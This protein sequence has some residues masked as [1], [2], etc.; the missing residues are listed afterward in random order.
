MTRF[1]TRLEGSRDYALASRLSLRPSVEAGLRHYSGGRVPPLMFLPKP[2]PAGV[3]TYALSTRRGDVL[4]RRGGDLG[5]PQPETVRGLCR[6]DRQRRI[7]TG[8]M[9]MPANSRPSGVWALGT[10][11]PAVPALAELALVDFLAARARPAGLRRARRRECLLHEPLRRLDVR[12]INDPQLGPCLCR[13]EL[14]GRPRSVLALDV[15]LDVVHL[16][17]VLDVRDLGQN[18]CAIDS[19]VSAVERRGSTSKQVANIIRRA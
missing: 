9:L 2:T 7:R 10:V 5:R 19:H 17:D 4:V 14:A 15:T 3:S 18:R 12:R 8:E 16:E 6:T 13:W 11:R 1:R